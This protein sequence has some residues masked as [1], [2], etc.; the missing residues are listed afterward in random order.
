MGKNRHSKDKLF[1]TAT[2]WSTQYGGKKSGQTALSRPL[3]FDHCA[4]SLAPFVTP[5]LL[6]SNGVV[7]DLENIVPYLKEYKCDPVTGDKMTIKNI[8]RLKME[9]NSEG[10]WH[11]LVYR[12]CLLFASLFFKI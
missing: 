8:I 6:G 7:F 5:V 12:Y 10:L 1:I 3:S 9:K 11:W 2:E 4:L